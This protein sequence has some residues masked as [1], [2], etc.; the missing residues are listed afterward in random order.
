MTSVITGDI[1]HSQSVDPKQWLSILKRELND[2]GKTPLNWEI[3]RG[4][5]FQVEVTRPE[6]ALERA[7]RIK[8]SVKCIK[9][10]DVRMAIGIGDKSYLSNSI[11]ESNGTAFIY[12]GEQF[13]Q[14]TKMKQNLAIAT[15]SPEFNDEMNL[16]IRLSLIAMNSWSAHS[17]EMVLLALSHPGKSQKELGEIIGIKQNAVSNRLKRAY[18]DEITSLMEMYRIKLN[19][20]L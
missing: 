9:E 6:E 13:E 10:I 19:K 4:D 15:P 14:L 5:S 17:A 1:I 20:M 16:F 7:I 3:Y 2:I 18:F 11:L 12:S 8:A